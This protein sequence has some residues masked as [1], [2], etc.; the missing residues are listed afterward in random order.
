MG[1]ALNL[2]ESDTPSYA[3]EPSNLWKDIASMTQACI[4]LRAMLLNH[5]ENPRWRCWSNYD[6]RL[7]FGE[8]DRKFY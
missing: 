6:K 7:G 5:I 4:V 3:Q 2:L 1:C 8:A